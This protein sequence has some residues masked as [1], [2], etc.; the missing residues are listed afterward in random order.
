MNLLQTLSSG[1]V[2]LALLWLAGCA[3]NPVTG[4][5][6]FVLMSVGQELQIGRQLDPE[7]KKQFGVYEAPELQGYVEEVGRKLA[8]HS[9]RAELSYR[10]TV[11]DSTDINAFA[12]PG[13]YIYVT[14]G[15]LAY[16]NSEAEL[17]AVLGHEIGHVTARHSV[18]QYSKAQAANIGAALAGI[19]VPELGAGIAQNLMSVMGTAIL[20]GYSRE[21]ELQADRLG[22]E[23]LARV[24]YDPRAI[25][26]TI[27]VL[28]NQELFAAELAKQE[29][30]EPRTYHGLFAT[31]PDNDTRLQQ[32]V[33]EASRH[34]AGNSRTERDAYLEKIEGLIFGD[35]PR[36]GAIRDGSFYHGE[37]GFALTFPRGWKLTNRPDK[38]QAKSPSGEAFM[39]LGLARGAKGTPQE[40]LRKLL[41]WG[42]AGA[43]ETA[44]INGLPAARANTSRLGTPILAAVIE[45]ENKAFVIGASAK[46]REAIERAAAEI[47]ETI[48]SFHPIT[49]EER[50][51]ARPY[52]IRT[53]VAKAGTRFSGLARTSPLGEN[54]ERHLRLLNGLYPDGEPTPGQIVKIV[55]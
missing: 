2:P 47:D 40:V 17:A 48:T 52:R 54:A 25:V 43:V 4:E 37:L 5:Q 15:L 55:E 19:L 42:Q 16:L 14:R 10:F 38:L 8:Q 33:A 46:S 1:I 35:S 45:L 6:N 31:H 30:R 24:G 26:E 50:T 7:V 23:Y 3:A 9:H 41:G 12:L 27:G 18:Q 44:T 39:E 53:L 49:E 51:R 29:G 11:V 28:K 36:Q 32:V 13:G 34:A 22:A 21:H 20:S